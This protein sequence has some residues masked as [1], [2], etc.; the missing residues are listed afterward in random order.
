M[1]LRANESGYEKPRPKRTSQSTRNKR[2]KLS[3]MNKA[4]K[5]QFKSYNQQ[6]R[7]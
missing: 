6:G 5:R 1:A 7:P 4:K 3:S 2:V